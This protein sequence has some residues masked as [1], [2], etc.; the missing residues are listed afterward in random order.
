MIVEAR[1]RKHGDEADGEP[2]YLLHMHAGERAAV[3]GG[4]NFQHAECADGGQDGQQPPIVIAG[5]ASGVSGHRGS[6]SSTSWEICGT[7]T[8]AGWR[9]FSAAGCTTAAGGAGVTGRCWAVMV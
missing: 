7:G 5:C 2:A 4:V 9:C 1:K 3:S 6:F 8:G